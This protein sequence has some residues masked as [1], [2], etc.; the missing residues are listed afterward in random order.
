MHVLQATFSKYTSDL[1]LP[2][3]NFSPESHEVRYSLFFLCIPNPSLKKLPLGA[4]EARLLQQLLG[5]QTSAEEVAERECDKGGGG[6]R[7]VAQL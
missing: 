4:R 3:T 6:E 1:C 2:V 7:G 5:E